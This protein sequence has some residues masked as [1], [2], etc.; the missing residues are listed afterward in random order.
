[1]QA[2]GRPKSIYSA[3]SLFHISLEQ[4][5]DAVVQMISDKAV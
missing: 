1:M 4:A 2:K 3:S 5:S